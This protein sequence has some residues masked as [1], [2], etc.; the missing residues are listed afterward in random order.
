MKNIILSFLAS[1]LL[2]SCAPEDIL[3]ATGNPG[4]VTVD[5]TV[6]SDPEMKTRAFADGSQLSQLK[7]YVYMQGS[8]GTPLMSQDI[9]MK[10]ADGKRCGSLSIDLPTGGVYDFVFLATSCPQ[11]DRNSKVYYDP[12]KRTVN[13]NYDR[14]SSNDEGVDCFF[15]VLKGVSMEKS[16]YSVTLRRPFAQLNIGTKDLVLYNEMASAELSTV[17]VSVDGVYKSVDVMDGSVQGSPVKVNMAAVSLPSGQVFPVSGA[18]YLAMNYLLVNE[19]KNVDVNMTASN[20]SSSFDV[21][22][23]KVPV[24][25]NYQTNVFG[26]LLTGENDF[27]VEINPVFGGQ[28]NKDYDDKWADY[29]L[30]LKVA[31][32][33]SYVSLNYRDSRNQNKSIDLIKYVDSNNIIKIKYEDLNIRQKSFSLSST[34]VTAVYKCNFN[35]FD[36]S[37]QLTNFFSCPY[38]VSAEGLMCNKG[39]NYSLKNMFNGCIRLV[40][41][42]FSQFDTSEVTSMEG[43]FFECRSLSSIDMTQFDTSSVRTM[44]SMFENCKSLESIDLSQNNLNNVTNMSSMFSNNTALNSV[45]FPLRNDNLSNTSRMFE[46]CSS[47]ESI[48]LSG[49]YTSNVEDMSYMFSGCTELESI[50]LSVIDVG[51][52]TNC[53][54]L[55][56]SCTSLTYVNLLNFNSPNLSEAGFM[57][58]HCSNLTNIDLSNMNLQNLAIAKAMFYGC[59]KLSTV[60]VSSFSKA[61]N[62]KD[63]SLMFGNC[64]SL[65]SI[66]L[67]C[68][69]TANVTNMSGMF[70]NSGIENVDLSHFDTSKVEDMSKMFYQCSS[71]KTVDMS[72]LKAPKVTTFSEMFAF[73]KIE[74]I[75]P[76]TQSVNASNMKRMFYECSSLKSIDLINFTT[77]NATNFE[78]M[79]S[80]C[81]SITQLDLSSFDTS[82]VTTMKDMFA[83][84]SYLKTID[85]SSFNTANVTDMSAMFHNCSRLLNLDV[86]SFDTSNVNTMRQM[87]SDVDLT[88]TDLSKFNTANVT[89]MAA[90]FQF[91]KASKLDLTNFDTS[92]VIAMFN[93]FSSVSSTSLDLSSFNTSNVT[94]VYGMFAN[95]RNLNDLHLNFNFAS[96]IPTSST[97]ESNYSD[98]FKECKTLKIIDGT[99]SNIKFN[100]DLSASPLSNESAVVIIEGL[101]NVNDNR[102][103]TFSKDTYDTLLESQFKM[104]EDKGWTIK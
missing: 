96:L 23:D 49:F 93:M 95:C 15:N 26:N 36:N 40:S 8:S 3:E 22:F 34:N 65:K 5:V 64:L 51:R 73:S 92:K 71:L 76:V 42:D 100:I 46:S 43:M 89:D 90:M 31:D 91:V 41:V 1:L 86:S 104:A 68:L 35:N 44:K 20:G 38:L 54:S 83:R 103:I 29:D 72:M 12:E 67:S 61:S 101:S 74:S 99:L 24:Q 59:T 7:C 6:P 57:F 75:I 102:V 69:K 88:N 32:N 10:F 97:I 4:M 30:V 79:F 85:L 52:L 11:D 27:T 28:A 50:D 70:S 39:K 17:G 87:F 58:S 94:N 19:R 47:L 37:G 18:S 56:S 55:L 77:T 81:S 98:L 78:Q 21:K 16:N 62:L 9:S 53:N 80:G 63:T 25:R 33:K 45:V 60:N 48:D 82:N 66:D 84:C 2:F 13:L 14:I